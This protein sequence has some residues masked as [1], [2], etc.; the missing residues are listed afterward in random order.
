MFHQLT[1]KF[2]LETPKGDAIAYF[3]IDEG[4]DQDLYWGCFVEATR[5]CWIFRNPEVR[6]SRNFTM[7]LDRPFPLPI[8]RQAD[9]RKFVPELQKGRTKP[10]T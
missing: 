4:R 5:E 1:E 7:A 9:G 8:K 3:V 6:L 10:W 2:Y